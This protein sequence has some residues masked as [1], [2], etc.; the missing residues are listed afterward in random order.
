MQ[1]VLPHNDADQ[2]SESATIF[3]YSKNGK[4]LILVDNSSNNTVLNI[5]DVSK[6]DQKTEA[7][8]LKLQSITHTGKIV[9]ISLSPQGNYLVTWERFSAENNQQDNLIVWHV[10]TGQVV[11]KFTQKTFIADLW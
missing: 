9:A 5:F 4:I 1:V 11:A 10:E 2:L 3:E 7:T 8:S 6:V